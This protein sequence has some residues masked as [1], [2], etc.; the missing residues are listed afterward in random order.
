M[1][2]DERVLRWAWLPRA[3]L[4]IT[5]GLALIVA[6]CG[7][8]APRSNG[9][10]TLASPSTARSSG[11]SAAPASSDN[12]DQQLLAYSQCMRSHGV[13]NFPDP[14]FIDGQVR[15]PGLA[16]TGIDPNSATFHAAGAACQS[17][18]TPPP[19]ARQQMSPQDQ[20]KWLQFAQC[21]RNHGVPDFPDPDFTNGGPKPFF[22]Y[23][24]TGVD[25]R[26]ATLNAAMQACRS[27]LPVING[28]SGSG[29]ASGTTPSPGTTSQ[30]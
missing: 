19:V 11:A 12:L 18:M 26:S 8:S 23:T 25:P 5:V 15:P 16:G 24:G 13:P 1:R 3:A 28:G 29:S 7:S 9:V 17:L 22:N 6:A 14:Q 27:V 20:A 10:V 21:V 30:P 2:H 4:I